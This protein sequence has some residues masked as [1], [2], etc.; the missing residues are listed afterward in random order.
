MLQVAI[1]SAP[2]LPAPSDEISVS[3]F[4]LPLYIQMDSYQ[5]LNLTP[6]VLS[7]SAG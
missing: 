6:A 2:D 4:C 1:D 5:S 3:L 7:T